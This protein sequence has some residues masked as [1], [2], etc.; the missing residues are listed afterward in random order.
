MLHG[1]LAAA[2]TVLQRSGEP[3]L[4]SVALG[5]VRVTSTAPL[6]EEPGSLTAYPPAPTAPQDGLPMW[7]SNDAVERHSPLPEQTT[8]RDPL[9]VARNPQ[10]VGPPESAEEGS[11]LDHAA[12]SSSWLRNPR[13]PF[14]CH[15]ALGSILHPAFSG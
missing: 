13:S 6:P 5:V 12:L 14:S 11:R 15:I 1:L 9:F 7:H 3:L 4:Q 8:D 10:R 2:M